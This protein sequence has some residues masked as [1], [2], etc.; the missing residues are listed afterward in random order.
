MIYYSQAGQDKWVHDIIGDKGF[1]VDIGAYDGVQTSNTY[2]LEQAGWNGICVEAN[3]GAGMLCTG[4]RSC[5]TIIKAV[6]NYCGWIGFTAD[7][8]HNYDGMPLVECDTLQGI[9]RKYV[10][11]NV[12]DYLSM[13]IEGHELTVLEK[14]PFDE[15]QFKLITIEHNLYCDGPAKKN[16]LYELLTRNGYTRVVDNAPCLDPNPAWYMQPYEDWYR[17]NDFKI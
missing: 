1:F 5:K 14:F 2:A 7:K 4:N 10:H 12:I 8:I 11:N 16:A 3:Y 13:D 9:L 6:T 17:H 15:F